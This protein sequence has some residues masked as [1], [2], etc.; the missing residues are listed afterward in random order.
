MLSGDVPILNGSA[1]SARRYALERDNLDQ[2]KGEQLSSSLRGLRLT[3]DVHNGRVAASGREPLAALFVRPFLSYADV[4]KLSEPL[5][6]V[7]FIG[8]SYEDVAAGIEERQRKIQE[9]LREV[10]ELEARATDPT[11]TE[12]DVVE[13]VDRIRA[14]EDRVKDLNIEVADLKRRYKPDPT[15]S[16][17]AQQEQAKALDAASNSV[18]G[19]CDEITKKRQAVQYGADTRYA[20]ELPDSKIIDRTTGQ[21]TAASREKRAKYS[22]L[23]KFGYQPEVIDRKADSF[24]ALSNNLVR[25]GYVRKASY[26]KTARDQPA[27]KR[28]PC[29]SVVYSEDTGKYY[30]AV[31]AKWARYSGKNGE[32]RLM[33]QLHPLIVE[34]VGAYN[35]DI[36]AKYPSLG[37]KGLA[38]EQ[39]GNHSEVRAVSAA[40]KDIEQ[41]TGKSADETVLGRLHVFNM[42][43]VGSE[44]Y[45]NGKNMRRC[46]NC[47]VLTRGVNCISDVD[48]YVKPLKAY[49][50]W[51]KQNNGGKSPPYNLLAMPS[52][53]KHLFG[54]N[55]ELG[56]EADVVDFASLDFDSDLGYTQDGVSSFSGEA[57]SHEEA[58]D[59]EQP[60]TATMQ[61]KKGALEGLTTLGIPKGTNPG[62]AKVEEINYVAGVPHGLRTAWD[63]AGNKIFEGNYAFG[64]LLS[65]TEYDAD[66][67]VSDVYQIDPQSDEYQLYL[68]YKGAEEPVH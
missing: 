29:F 47:K 64:I 50:D 67:K 58:I 8:A 60:I 4:V 26:D 39:P 59:G 21:E 14:L 10:R 68:A 36:I 62:G 40:L 49:Q 54:I 53:N 42:R 43:V 65:G 31:N 13:A 9:G 38:F 48:G 66:G 34:R 5:P 11:A 30:E 52:S 56:E 51:Y 45:G 19:L 2:A 33:K 23:G 27:Y 57:V 25:E 61:F 15:L 3:G 35:K 24:R 16:R 22:L 44:E 7:S 46:N 18:S 17:Q 55:L 28:S 41:V 63:D 37:R 20:V 32:R 6:F 1:Q 12:E